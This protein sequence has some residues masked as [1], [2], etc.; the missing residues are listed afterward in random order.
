MLAL[1]LLLNMAQTLEMLSVRAVVN[2]TDISDTASLNANTLLSA[3]NSSCA[4]VA[5]AYSEM[6]YISVNQ[7]SRVDTSADTTFSV[8]ASAMTQ[9][10]YDEANVQTECTFEGAGSSPT[11]SYINI[12]RQFSFG[13]PGASG[14]LGTP[15]A[16]VTKIAL[17][18]AAMAGAVDAA[19][20]TMSISVESVELVVVATV[21]SAATNVSVVSSEL[22][23]ALD[24]AVF[25]PAVGVPS[26]ALAFSFDTVTS[27]SPPPPPPRPAPPPPF[28]ED[29]FTYELMLRPAWASAFARTL[30]G[31]N[32]SA[33]AV[34]VIW[35]R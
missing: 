27:A 20:F 4:P 24:P 22:A 10:C 5:A 1:A 26:S 8:L 35:W 31:W 3:A 6:L 21:T 19:S 33:G 16:N 23:E 29:R 18:V 14:S 2:F 9:I 28:A 25:G 15:T 34:Q 13:V 17:D 11:Q 7:L 32:P 12:R 30:M